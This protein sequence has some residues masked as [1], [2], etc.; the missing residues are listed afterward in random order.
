MN[1]PKVYEIV[2]WDAKTFLT[3]PSRIRFKNAKDMMEAR[4]DIMND[5]D[6]KVKVTT[7]GKTSIH[8]VRFDVIKQDFYEGNIVFE[9]AGDP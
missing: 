3:A 7:G 9:A 4:S 2:D 1:Q 8:L 5:K 6:I